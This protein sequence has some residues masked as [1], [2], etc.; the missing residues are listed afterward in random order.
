[1][2]FNY[3]SA[4]LLNWYKIQDVKITPW[5]MKHLDMDIQLPLFGTLID[6]NQWDLALTL[7]QLFFNLLEIWIFI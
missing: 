5:E 4:I 6:L 1:M 2:Y 3:F 7:T